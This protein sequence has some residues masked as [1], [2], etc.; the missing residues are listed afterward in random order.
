LEDFDNQK[1]DYSERVREEVFSE[2]GLPVLEVLG[3]S[4][5]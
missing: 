5:A 2:T 3:N 4:E 1:Y